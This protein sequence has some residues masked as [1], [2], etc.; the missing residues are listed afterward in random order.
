MLR[1]LLIGTALALLQACASPAPVATRE[2]ATD[3]VPDKAPI[4]AKPPERAFPE[5][6]VYPLLLAE[7]AMRRRAFDVALEQYMEQAP[8]LRD[9]GVSAHATHLAQYMAQERAALEAVQLWLELEPDNIEANNTLAIL[10]IRQGRAAE[11]LP[12]MARLAAEG[13]EVNFPALLSGF[14]NLD[15]VQRATLVDGINKLA[16]EHPDDVQ[17]LLTQAMVLAEQEQFDPAL[18]TLHRLFEL[19]PNQSQAALLEGRILLAKNSPKP[20]ARIE[21]VLEQNPEDTQIRLQYARLLTATD[22]AA[23]VN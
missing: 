5:D 23:A 13:E 21:K 12:H 15:A 14:K 18:E 16:L 8:Q 9:A 11:A 6:S 22:M 10:L 7:F 3:A 1:L 17:L 2:T 4:A 19:Q 20:Y